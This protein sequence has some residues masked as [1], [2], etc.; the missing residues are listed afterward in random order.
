[1]FSSV[2]GHMSDWSRLI[3][4]FFKGGSF[5]PAL[6]PLSENLS[7]TKNC[8]SDY[9]PE[10]HLQAFIFMYICVL[11]LDIWLLLLMLFKVDFVNF[12][13]SGINIRYLSQV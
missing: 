7:K 4:L 3:S 1:M 8:I 9:H 10:Q 5:I 12:T 11:H 2:I 13:K 6:V